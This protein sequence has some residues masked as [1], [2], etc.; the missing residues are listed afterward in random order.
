VY[1]SEAPNPI[2]ENY[3]G[4]INIANIR[5]NYPLAKIKSEA[6]L[7]NTTRRDFNKRIVRLFHTFG[8]GI[9]SNDGRSFSDFLS[10]GMTSTPP[11]L[12][13][14]GEQ[15]RTYSYLEDS[16]AGIF[17]VLFS[18]CEKPVNVG[19]EKAVTVLEFAELVS[20]ISGLEGEVDFATLPAG[21]Q[22]SPNDVIVPST[23]LLRSLGWVESVS[24]DEG[25]R[26]TLLWMRAFYK[27]QS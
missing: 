1:G 8:P 12:H 11:V 16:A 27:S 7:T 6:L 10:N 24:L 15:V 18:N 5:S 2:E 19:S 9:N 26:R 17:T 14:K 23:E 20:K 3:V 13:S 21:H 25:I 4:E 22:I